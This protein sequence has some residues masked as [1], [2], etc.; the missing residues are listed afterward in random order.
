MG[1]IIASGNLK[2]GTGKSTIAVNLACALAAG[3]RSVILIDIDPQ[4]TAADWAGHGDLPVRVIADAPV[5]L[6]SPGRWPKRVMERARAVDLVVLDLPPL[7]G[8]VMTS[9]LMI[10]DL[11]L[12][13]ITPSAVDVRPTAEALRL[14]RMARESRQGQ[15][16]K[17][18][19]VPNRVDYSARYDAATRTAV[20][21][22]RERWAPPIRQHTDFVNAFAAGSW[23]GAHAPAGRAAFDLLALRGAV[24]ERLG[25]GEAATPVKI[26]A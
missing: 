10:V 6:H 20:D 19:L 26:P 17:A 22:L 4:G 8:R 24:E 7:V 25:W 9:A 3:G 1:Q 13:P 5:D 12:I 18:L 2:G 21:S 16:P 15:R 14:V 23:V 11:I